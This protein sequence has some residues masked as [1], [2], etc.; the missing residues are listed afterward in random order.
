[1]RSDGDGSSGYLLNK[2]WT[3]LT[4]DDA[5]SRQTM[6]NWYAYGPKT[7]SL[8]FDAV[9]GV[10]GVFIAHS[11]ISLSG[12]VI[13]GVCAIG[14]AAWLHH[15]LVYQPHRRREFFVRNLKFLEDR[16]KADDENLRTVRTVYRLANDGIAVTWSALSA[17]R[18]RF[19]NDWRA[20]SS[21][22]Q[23]VQVGDKI[24]LTKYPALSKNDTPDRW[25]CQH[26]SDGMQR[27]LVF[28]DIVIPKM[29][30]M[31]AP[32]GGYDAADARL[33]KGI[34]STYTGIDA[35]KKFVQ[36]ENAVRSA[37]P[38]NGPRNGPRFVAWSLFGRL[39][40]YVAQNFADTA[41]VHFDGENEG[42]AVVTALSQHQTGGV[43]Y[44]DI[45]G[46]QFEEVVPKRRFLQGEHLITAVL[47][48]Q[49]LA[50][51]ASI[52]GA[53][54]PGEELETWTT[55]LLTG[56]RLIPA[57]GAYIRRTETLDAV[58]VDNRAQGI[59]NNRA[60]RIRMSIVDELCNI[61][62]LR[63]LKP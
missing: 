4:G 27:Y 49:K 2:G 35:L 26:I 19:E 34:P 29:Y 62:A 33:Q 43:G 42:P 52:R 55:A 13:F 16:T 54:E 6:W 28:V 8:A 46:M 1:M 57:Q 47:I 20:R 56:E 15:A 11:G 17:E 45:A 24:Q 30:P 39:S 23:M 14:G 21:T 31:L 38:R 7:R 59:R 51:A 63:L 58:R 44:P 53:F 48:A 37:A 50:D 61:A 60:R 40:N 36:L 12:S 22:E 41:D 32:D 3:Y 10:T 5:V 25:Q 18:K 9:K